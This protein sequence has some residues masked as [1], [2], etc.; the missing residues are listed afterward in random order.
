MRTKGM[1][2][3]AYKGRQAGYGGSPEKTSV[4]FQRQYWGS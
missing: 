1:K 3:K 2:L 4:D